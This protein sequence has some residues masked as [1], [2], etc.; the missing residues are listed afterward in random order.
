[1]SD[2]TEDL[3]G[4]L[5]KNPSKR[6]DKKDPDYTGSCI[7]GGNAY[8]MDAWINESRDG[9]K[10]MGLKFKLKPGQSP[11]IQGGQIISDP[12]AD[13]DDEIPF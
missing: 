3:R 5:F 10:Y 9:T 8:F 2:R 11:K 7:I 13:F 4:A 12:P 1:M 6:P